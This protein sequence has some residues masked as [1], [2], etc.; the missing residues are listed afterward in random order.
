LL[1]LICNI[2]WPICIAIIIAAIAKSPF[3]Q[4]MVRSA[5]DFK[6]EELKSKQH[7]NTSNASN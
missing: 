6:K 2:A 5:Y 3:L 4:Q 7:G 1:N